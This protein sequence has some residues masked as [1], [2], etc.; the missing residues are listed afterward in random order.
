MKMTEKELHLV[1]EE[2]EGYRIEFKETFSGLDKEMAAFANASGGRIFL[3]ISDDN[4][5]T[6]VRNSNKLKSQVQDIANNCQP[7]I[8]ITIDEYKDI[9]I[10]TVREGEDKP[11]K[12]SSGFYTRVGPNSQKLSRNEIVDFFKSEGKIRYDELFQV[13]FDYETH[14]D[15][16]KFDRFQRLAGISRVMDAID[17]MSNLGIAEKQEGKIIFNNTGIFFFAKNLQDIYY[18]T[19]VV[20]ALYKGNEKVD[21]LDR[22]DFNEDI[23][24][25]IDGAMNFLKQYIP[26][27]Y[28]MTGE[29]RRR[30]IPEIP[31]EA[32]REAVIN[33]VAHRDYFEKGS[34]IMVEMFDD[35]IEISNFGGLVK[36]LKP[37]DFGKKS[38]LRNPNIAN[39]LHRIGYIEKMGTGINKMQRAM[40]NAGLQPI[41]FEFSNFF[42]A[43]FNR[44]VTI[45]NGAENGAVSGKNV[46]MKAFKKIEKEI[47]NGAVFGAV[48]EATIKRLQKVLYALDEMSFLK[49][50]HL[51]VKSGIPRRT[52]QRDLALLKENRLVVFKGSPK[53]GGYVLTE[54][55][56]KLA[57]EIID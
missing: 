2:G 37:E 18:H 23:I 12:C 1:L 34:N 28:E 5:I 15:T 47:L 17:I 25:N 40:K 51:V 24:G 20:C 7:P 45:K 13:K 42:T 53:T 41:Q 33:A 38:V 32:L 16:G 39:L 43:I 9:L 30:E 36:S 44:P 50:S 46:D 26:V 19:A 11:Y 48:K 8:R 22:R 27:R 31:Y 10:L 4:K 21:V 52:L 56:K 29:P 14:F 3:G 49:I 35:R 6:G 55:G 57:R 54:K